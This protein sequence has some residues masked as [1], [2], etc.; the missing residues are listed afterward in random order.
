[1]LKINSIF[2]SISGEAGGFPQG[3]WTTF[4]RLQGCNLL[5]KWPCD[6]PY[7]Q[8]ASDLH[9]EMEI[10]DIMRMVKNEHVLITGGEPLLQEE[11]PELIWELLKHGRIVQVE[12]NG[13]LP[14][15]AIPVHWVIDRKGP[16]SGMTGLMR[17]LKELSTNI[18]QIQ[19][20]GGNVY[21]KWVISDEEDVDYMIEEM[22]ILLRSFFWNSA[23]V[24]FIVSPINA[25]GNKII[26]IIE[27][28]KETDCLLLNNIIFSVQLHKIFKMP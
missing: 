22:N 27:R 2:E 9:Y 23:L 21:L 25:E 3:T 5:C 7:A 19:Q 14:I 20:C 11:M 6:T 1:M 26:D 10:P 8:A 12:T 4:I 15:P 16:S 24:P 28:I 17:S 18:E 13:S